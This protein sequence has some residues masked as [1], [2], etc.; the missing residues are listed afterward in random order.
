M[1]FR[2]LRQMSPWIDVLDLIALRSFLGNIYFE[3]DRQAKV[4]RISVVK[5]L[6]VPTSMVHASQMARPDAFRLLCC[7]GPFLAAGS[8]VNAWSRRRTSGKRPVA[9]AEF[10]I[11]T[12]PRPGTASGVDLRITGK[13]LHIGDSRSSMP[14]AGLREDGEGAQT[15]IHTVRRSSCA[16]GT[17]RCWSK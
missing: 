8:R 13:L 9:S 7:M 14:L 12:R 1:R 2:S 17:P 16:Q 15:P 5:Q 10:R 6:T 3:A 4:Y 11:A